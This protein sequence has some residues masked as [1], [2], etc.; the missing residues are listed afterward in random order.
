LI[1]IEEGRMSE[2]EKDKGKVKEIKVGEKIT[3]TETVTVIKIRGEAT[4]ELEQLPQNFRQEVLDEAVELSKNTIHPYD[5]TLEEVK[6]AK[7][8]KGVQS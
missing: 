1:R 7:K 3:V 4:K 6:E 8:K 5:V 2:E